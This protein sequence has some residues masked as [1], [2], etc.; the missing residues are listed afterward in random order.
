MKLHQLLITAPAHKLTTAWK[1]I[2]I[3]EASTRKPKQQSNRFPRRYNQRNS[4]QYSM[5]PC[6][7]EPAYFSYV[8]CFGVNI[9]SQIH[10]SKD[11][12]Y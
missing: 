8:L 7:T 6:K 11:Y 5:D 4:I 2:Y 9:C 10:V 12:I 3:K 1:Y